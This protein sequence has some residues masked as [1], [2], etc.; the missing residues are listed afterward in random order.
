VARR[1]AT[2]GSSEV[3]A[4]VPALYG[5]EGSGDHERR[6]VMTRSR[7]AITSASARIALSLVVLGLAGC[8]YSFKSGSSAS[9][10]SGKPAV[11]DGDPSSGK[12]TR[13][14]IAEA[15][16]S[17]PSEPAEPDEGGRPDEGPT[18][19]PPA[20]EPPPV[21]EPRL[22]AVCRVQ[23]ATLEELCHRTL[24]PI[25]ADDLDA[26]VGQLA[27]GI[28]VT[29]PT[30]RGDLRR[31][32]GPTAVQDMATRVG[33]LRALLHLRPT[34]RVVGTLANDCRQCRRAFVAF[35]A[36]TRSG[37]FTVGVEMTQPPAIVSV[38]LGSHMRRRHLG[39]LRQ[40][41]RT[42]PEKPTV[43]V[44]SAKAEPEPSHEIVAPAPAPEAKPTLEV[45]P[46]EPK[47][48]R[49]RAE[50]VVPEKKPEP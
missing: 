48:K 13:K 17:E 25:A 24:D 2:S 50:L 21:V 39:A 8:S 9:T 31:V 46:S 12:P 16:P 26:W 1:R 15:D 34:D 36:N 37:T 22:T 27:T 49:K 28:V 47:P 35:E 4:I 45:E 41:T 40:P 20:A 44:P 14:P 38:E 19:T 3:L 23:D 43:V 5:A 29:R 7:I 11:D 42:P 18:R 32:E 6:H 10:E 33:G 30:H